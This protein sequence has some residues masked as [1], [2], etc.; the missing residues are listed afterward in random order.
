VLNILFG[1]GIY[2]FD[3]SVEWFGLIL[4]FAGNMWSEDFSFAF[5]DGEQWNMM[6]TLEKKVGGLFEEVESL[7]KNVNG[8][9]WDFEE[10]VECDAVVWSR[11]RGAGPFLEE[12]EPEP[13]PPELWAAPAL[14][15]FH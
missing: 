3:L 6:R 12:P 1:C 14:F 2:V 7:G 5:E 8:V 13:E 4:F 10:D 11:S 15:I 9:L